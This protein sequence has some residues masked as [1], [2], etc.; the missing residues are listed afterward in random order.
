MRPG[1]GERTAVIRR[2]RADYVKYMK[3]KELLK[4]RGGI[5]KLLRS[6]GIDYK[7]S[8]PPAYVTDGP[9]RHNPIPFRFLA[10]MDVLKFQ[11]RVVEKS[12][13]EEQK[14]KEE[15]QERMDRRG[16]NE[17]RG[18]PKGKRENRAVY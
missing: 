2:M 18:S 7:E 5:F 4:S 17:T 11:H 14:E 13:K 3:E 8:I 1:E 16:T 10:P 6:T 15:R 12:R 9:V